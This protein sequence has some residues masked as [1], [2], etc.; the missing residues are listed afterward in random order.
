MRNLLPALALALAA[1]LA[2]GCRRR[3]PAPRQ[4]EKPA[5]LARIAWGEPEK[6]LQAGILVPA[7]WPHPL[8]ASPLLRCQCITGV[9]LYVRNRS[10]RLPRGCD[11][12]ARVSLRSC[13]VDEA[14]VSVSACP[15]EPD[16]APV[17]PLLLDGEAHRV[18]SASFH[19]SD[20][21]RRLLGGDDE[22]GEHRVKIRGHVRMTVHPV[23][24]SGRIIGPP[25][26]VRLEAGPAVSIIEVEEP[27][28]EEDAGQP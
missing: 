7:R 2:A 8:P 3:P 25:V 9:S 28:G 5:W 14:S 26:S 4:G 24:R 20:G 13:S 18:Y 22:A 23:D 12:S 21:G 17:V 27:E 19:T 10:L 11:G 6:G 15:L 16:K 1:C